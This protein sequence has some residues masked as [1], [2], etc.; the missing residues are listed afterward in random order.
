MEFDDAEIVGMWAKSAFWG[1]LGR[2]KPRAIMLYGDHVIDRRNIKVPVSLR[3][4]TFNLEGTFK[5]GTG[6]IVILH[7]SV[8]ICTFTRQC[9]IRVNGQ[10]VAC[11]EVEPQ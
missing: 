7:A 6:E 9:E 1:L 11:Q 4:W 2:P 5:L 10:I 3:A 8:T